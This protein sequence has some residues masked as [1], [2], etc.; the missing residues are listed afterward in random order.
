MAFNKFDEAGSGQKFGTWDGVFASCLLNIFGAIM[1]L[2][3]GWVV[4]EAGVLGAMLIILISAIV[5]GLTTLSMSAIA[6]NGE[7]MA[8]GAYYLISRALGPAIGGSVGVLFSLGQS[9]A[10]S[11]YVIAC[12]E[13]MVD[14]IG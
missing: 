4:G 3:L 8:G 1:F 14:V 6:T 12:A 11:M 13:T 9:V 2:R 10:C 7:V 5:T